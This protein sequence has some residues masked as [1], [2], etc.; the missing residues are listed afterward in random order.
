[1]KLISHMNTGTKISNLI[2]TSGD[3]LLKQS[4]NVNALI[5]KTKEKIH[6]K[7]ELEKHLTEIQCYS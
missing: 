6:K 1:M 7:I 2:V 5:N 4:I 3:N